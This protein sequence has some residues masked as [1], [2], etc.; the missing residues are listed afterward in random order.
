MIWQ[1]WLFLAGTVIN[2]AALWPAIRGKDKP[3]LKTSALTG[4]VVAAYVVGFATLG[5]KVSALATAVLAVGWII[6]AIQK[7]NRRKNN[8]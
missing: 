1:D 6:L 7:F 8:G 4:A 3:P 2:A 5:L